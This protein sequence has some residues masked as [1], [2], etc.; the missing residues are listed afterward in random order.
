MRWG[1]MVANAFAAIFMICGLALIFLVAG[2]PLFPR[3]QVRVVVLVP[4]KRETTSSIAARRQQLPAV[5]DL[6]RE[7]ENLLE[8][9][10]R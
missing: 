4:A 1:E 7:G 5:F 10:R 6:A 9:R 8:S 2:R 3:R